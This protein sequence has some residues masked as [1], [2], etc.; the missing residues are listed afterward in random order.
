V[1]FEALPVPVT[2]AINPILHLPVTA[3]YHYIYF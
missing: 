1:Q 3:M 2:R